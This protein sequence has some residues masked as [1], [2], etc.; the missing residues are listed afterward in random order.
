L[1]YYKEWV[2]AWPHD[3]SK[4]AVQQHYE[5]TGEDESEQLLNMM[6]YQTHGE[7]KHMMG[8]DIRIRRDPLTMRMTEE[9]IKQ[10]HF[11]AL[12]GS[13]FVATQIQQFFTVQV[14]NPHT[15]FHEY[16]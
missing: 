3:T 4:E 11:S 1:A 10:G 7:Y 6:R 16:L 5:L 2:K 14:E 9:E 15:P 13:L 8:T 12:V